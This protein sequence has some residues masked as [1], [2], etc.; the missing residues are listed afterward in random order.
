MPL[1]SAGVVFD[2]SLA[3]CTPQGVS[4]APAP[5]HLFIVMNRLFTILTLVSALAVSATPAS[6]QDKTGSNQLSRSTLSA[7]TTSSGRLG[8]H[9]SLR[10]GTT[11]ITQSVSQVIE[12]ANAIACFNSAEGI[13]LDNSFFRVFDL[14]AEGVAEFTATSV[15]FGIE[16]AVS[17]TGTQPASL[18]FYTLS[19]AFTRANLT[20]IGSTSFDIPDQDLSL[21]TVAVSGVEMATNAA[22]FVVELR[23]EATGNAFFPGT[24]NAGE[25]APTYIASD[26][27]SL[28]DPV[29]YASIG[30]PMTGWVLNVTGNTA[31]ISGPNLLVSPG[32][33]AFGRVEIGET[34]AATTITLTNNGTADATI[35]SITS[36]G[37][38]FTLDQTGADL[39][40][41]VGESTTISVTYAPTATGDDTGTITVTSNDPN[42]PQTI[43]LFGTGFALPPNDD[44]A[45]A[46]V[47]TADGTYTGTNVEATNEGPEDAAPCG[48][49]AVNSV[50]WTYTPTTSGTISVDLS[51]STFDTVLSLH[52]PGTTPFACNDDA[53]GTPQSALVGVPVT[54]DSPVLIRIA[55][56]FAAEGDITL[57]LISD[58]AGPGVTI[59]PETITFG[60]TPVGATQTRT[61][62]ITNTGA[63]PVNLTAA[64]VTGSA[65]VTVSGFTAGTLAPDATQ[66]LS[67]TFAPTAAGP[68]GATLS[69]TSDA[70]DSPDTVEIVGNATTGGPTP[71]PSIDTPIDIPDVDAAGIT[72][73]IVVPAGNSIIANL[74]V[75][76]DI[77]HTFT[78]DLSAILTKDALTSALVDRPGVPTGPFGCS[79]DDI[80]ILVS[81][82]NATDA[83]E[84]TCIDPAGQA[85][86]AG[87]RYSPN[88]PLA[89]FAN[90]PAAGSYTLTVTDNSGGD[91]GTLN[92]WALLIDFSVAGENG[93]STAVSRLSVAPNPLAGQGQIDLTVAT[94][95]DVRVVLFDALGREV[96]VLFDRAM[97]AGQQAYVGFTTTNLP[98]GVYVVRATGTDLNLT[99]RVTVVR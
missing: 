8:A 20:R 93:A 23:L 34:T 85:Y 36:S 51:G 17:G 76:L 46:T 95:Q 67:L 37:G 61:V 73:T 64:T 79:G 16:T 28:P 66:T 84:T 83:V 89:V 96:Q 68:A 97:T 92:L 45:D 63:T 7:K 50:W 19:G 29:T 62:T 98:A 39:S 43:N 82:L 70:P 78:G 18:N 48:L 30:A 47:I 31:P 87:G 5:F 35:S 32:S 1:V 86:E 71:F 15:E 74:N 27:C 80:D 3:S 22:Q 11:T 26:G 90:T 25:E 52:Q 21:F 13:T 9:E 60:N 58:L 33:V 49:D 41:A 59:T 91:T 88:T 40:L 75:A 54:R 77:T 55:G 81:D 53:F 56:F 24:N 69:V 2:K 6:A 94:A 99:Q 10:G 57:T 4:S 44:I 12:P 42:S 65:A 72:S 38:P 14:S